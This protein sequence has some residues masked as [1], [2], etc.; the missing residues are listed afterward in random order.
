MSNKTLGTLLGLWIALGV[1]AIPTLV[2]AVDIREVPNPR[3]LNKGWVSDGARVL[4]PQAIASLNQ[5][6]SELEAKTG[7]EL[8]VVTVTDTQPYPTPKDYATALF[9]EWK[10]GKKGADNGVLLLV[11][12]K[13]RRVEIETG[14]GAEG[15]LPDAR[16]GNIIRNHIIPR[17]KQE[18]YQGGIIDGTRELIKVLQ[19]LPIEGP[20]DAPTGDDY[21][22]GLDLLVLGGGIGAIGGTLYYIK[23]RKR[24]LSPRG[25]SW[26]YG[27]GGN[28]KFHCAECKAL[29]ERVKDDEV[30]SNLNY[31]QKV[32]QEINSTKYEGWR[33]GKC[34]TQSAGLTYHLRGYKLSSQY[35]LCPN[36]QEYTIITEVHILQPATTFSNGLQRRISQCM[37]C[38]ISRVTDELIPR[39]T[40]V[41][42]VSGGGYSGSGGYSGGGSSGGGGDFGGGSSGGG[43]AGD[44][45]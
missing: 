39:I 13:D 5:S 21:S 9:N 16:T 7:T 14:Y 18:D 10:I 6:L 38:D 20:S 40:P 32:A 44:S 43:G 37:S 30:Q 31:P 15:V 3:K 11:S 25:R 35:E 24:Y 33:C 22:P 27:S 41:V 4:S 36:C 28:P 12:L 29:M 17:F 8:A 2:Y 23:N 34:S 1:G 42:V 19:N 26:S 45:W